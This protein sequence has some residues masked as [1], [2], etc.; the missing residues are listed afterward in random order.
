MVTMT[1]QGHIY[2]LIM[3]SSHE[4]VYRVVWSLVL[5]AE[6]GGAW[7]CGRNWVELGVVGGVGESLVLWAELGGA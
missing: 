1:V 4:H 3:Q 7:C 6:L 2:G 5:W